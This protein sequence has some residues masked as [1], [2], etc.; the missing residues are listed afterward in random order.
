MK[1]CGG[2]EG[3]K[4]RALVVVAKAPLEGLVKT[5]L[6]PYL[7]PAQAADFYECLLSD[8]LAKM[9][10][11][12]GGDL[13]LAFAPEG[14]D[15]FRRNHAGRRLLAQRGADLGER[16]HH[17]FVDLFRMDYHEIVVVDSDSPTVP[18]SAVRQAYEALGKQ[19]SEVVVLGPSD[20]GGYYLVG[21]KYPAREMFHDIP[22]STDRVLDTTLRR[23]RGLGF[24]VAL[25]PRA[26]DI[27][28]QEDLERLWKDFVAS[29]QLRDLAP[30]TFAYIRNLLGLQAC[31]DRDRAHKPG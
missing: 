17:I 12:E 20:D 2:R 19:N 16:L 15:Y 31:D 1:L 28:V 8:I 10:R 27:D 22:W 24:K 30:K 21:L 5:R 6:C 7:R 9:N 11:Y 23:A 29:D 25:L 26:Y 4:A 14:E 13:W 18:L 3:E